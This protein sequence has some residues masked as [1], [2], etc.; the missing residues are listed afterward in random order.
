ML[1]RN[2]KIKRKTRFFHIILRFIVGSREFFI[3]LKSEDF[4]TKF[5]N[6]NLFTCRRELACHGQEITIKLINSII[7]PVIC[8]SPLL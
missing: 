4:L 3:S 1:I 8:V 6:L 5:K 2:F 7:F